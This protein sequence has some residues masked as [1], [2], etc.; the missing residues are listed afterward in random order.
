LNGPS[1]EYLTQPVDVSESLVGLATFTGIVSATYPPSPGDIVEGSFEFHW[2]LGETEIFDTAVD[3]NSNADIVSSGNISTCTFSDIPFTDSGKT[4]SVVTDYIPADGEG[5]ANN[6][7]LRSNLATLISFPEILINTQPTDIIVG[8]GLEATLSVDAEI[9]PSNDETLLYQWQIDGN[10]LINGSQTLSE[11]TEAESASL[12]VTSD[13]GDNFTIDFFQLATFSNF[14]SNRTYTITSDADITTRIFAVGAGGGRSIVRKVSGGSGGAAQGITTFYSGETYIL[15]IGGAGQNGG[16]GGF[17]GGG[18]GGGGHGR[19]GGGG[20][21]TGL[22]KGSVSQSNAIII[23]GG[24]GGGSNDPATGGAG[25]GTSGG[26]GSNGPGPRGGGGGTQ[27]SG[28][29]GGS[30][31]GGALQG[32]PGAAGGGGGYFGGAGGNGFGGCCADGAGGGGSGFLSPTLLKESSFSSSNSAG[33]GN[34]SG[35]GTFKID[36]VS[37]V[38]QIVVEASGVNSPNLTLGTDDSNFGGVVRCVMSASNVQN[39]PLESNPVSYE[40]VD[41][42]NIVNFESYTFDNQYKTSTV[43]FDSTSNYTIDSSTFGSDYSIIQFHSTEKSVPVYVQMSAS[44]GADNG[45]YVGGQGG[46]SI[47]EFTMDRNV[48]YTL[49]G[50]ANNSA[51]FLYR[52]SNLIAVVGEGGDAGTSGDGGAGGGISIPGEGGGGRLGGSGGTKINTGTLSLS[53]SYG[54]VY[55]T[56]GIV[57]YPGDSVAQ[58]PD[59]GKTISCTKGSYWID[60]GIAACSD[61]SS[62]EIKFVNVDGT[63]IDSSSNIIRGFKP[64]YTMSNTSGLEINNGGRG[65]S[66]A[67][68]GGGGTSG[69][70]GGGGSGYTDGSVTVTTAVLGGNNEVSTVTIR[71]TPFP[72]VT[73]FETAIFTVGRSASY[74]NTIEF[75]RQSG[76]GPDRIVFGPNSGTVTVSMSP[77]AI[78]NLER[79]TVN[80]SPG[81]SLRLSGAQLQLE[82]SGGNDWDDLTVTPTTQSNVGN[83]NGGQFTSTT[84]FQF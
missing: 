48:E 55:E 69:S 15:K 84:R 82:D 65:G 32:G 57:L 56:S 60:Q 74:S 78:Y 18:N 81:G 72:V 30:G 50:I 19:G 3:S 40:V 46:V 28:G 26:N 51:L 77:G 33:G 37:I 80:G 79:T 1:L 75:V 61:N 73:L 9:F 58:S 16:S 12:T 67:T 14:V 24:G 4:V 54:S 17:S 10:N 68:G 62:S 52:G 23:A 59:G 29:S 76:E 2:F 42:R 64:G 71:T 27:S 41:T 66:G 20:G 35:N 53:G 5:N 44:K 63:T 47:I 31:G 39:S 45:S 25:G 21:L 83:L 8:S 34:P 6:D 7:N 13:A 36:R 11:T 38:K 49:I 22:F 70:G 43:N